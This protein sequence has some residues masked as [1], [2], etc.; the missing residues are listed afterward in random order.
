MY[1]KC[2]FQICFLNI[3]YYWEIGNIKYSYLFKYQF[4]YLLF[5]TSFFKID[6][7]YFLMHIHFISIFHYFDGVIESMCRVTVDTI[8]KL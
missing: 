8:V 5:E 4:A 7:F 1:N 6:S 3:K 2:N